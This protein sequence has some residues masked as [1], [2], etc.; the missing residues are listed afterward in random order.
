MKMVLDS[1]HSFISSWKRPH[2]E[3]QYS[4]NWVASSNSFVSKGGCNICLK[5]LIQKQRPL[6]LWL[7]KPLSFAVESGVSIATVS[8]AWVFSIL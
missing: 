7:A 3:I 2:I 1:L 6:R 8:R 5:A 4:L